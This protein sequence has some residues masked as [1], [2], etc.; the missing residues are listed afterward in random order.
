MDRGLGALQG[1][2][3]REGLHCLPLGLCYILLLWH[4]SARGIGIIGIGA[5][6]VCI[7]YKIFGFMY[8]Q[9]CYLGIGTVVLGII[10][11]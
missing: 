9:C 1:R 5:S 3:G 10:L 4:Q 2:R 7:W 6:I 8:I 11:G